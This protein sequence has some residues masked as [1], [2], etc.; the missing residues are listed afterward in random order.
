MRGI[1]CKPADR[2]LKVIRACSLSKVCL[3]LSD[4]ELTKGGSSRNEMSKEREVANMHKRETMKGIMTSK[5]GQ[6]RPGGAI[7]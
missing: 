6:Q 4:S 3:N 1:R 2:V 5:I 7:L